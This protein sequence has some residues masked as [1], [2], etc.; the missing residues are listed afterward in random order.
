MR[1]LRDNVLRTRWL[2][3]SEWLKEQDIGAVL[4]TNA[5]DVRW[6]TG[7]SGSNGAALA[8]ADD[9]PLLATDGRYSEQA[10]GECPEVELV[11]TRELIDQLLMRL[12]EHSVTTLAVDPASLTLAQFRLISA[13]PALFG[14]AVREL[15]T[16]VSHLRMTKDRY[17][18]DALAEACRIST[19]S[20]AVVM[21]AI[22]VGMTEVHLARML[23][24]VM[25]DHGAHD[26]A[27]P[28][29]VAAGENGGQPHH[30]PSTRPIEEGD[31]VTI[32]FG[33]AIDGYH[34]DCTRTVIVGADPAD[35]QVEMYETVRRAA[36]AARAAAGPGVPTTVVDAAARTLISDAGFGEYFVHGVGHGVG[37]D[38][39]EAP[40]LNSSTT[41]TLGL[42][43][44]F[45]VEPGIYIPGKGG[46]RI[47]DTCVLR[48]DGLAI[49]TKYPRGLTRVG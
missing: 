43:I 44:P 32:D 3:T 42:A 9:P 40:M 14:I 29:I 38:I 19:E 20:L 49:L 26:R 31:L 23:E 36:K 48:S 6:L 15:A 33:A 30:S 46:V 21:A 41:D 13:H 47:E 16:P 12:R 5:S 11:I 39:H 18:L 37:L 7:Y 1:S 34:A 27:F 22:N 25:G 17:E 35:W 45:T 8:L 4:L 2:H 10:S 24:G 28:T